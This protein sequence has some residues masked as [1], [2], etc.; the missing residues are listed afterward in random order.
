[1]T[2]FIT[3]VRYNLTLKLSVT[4]VMHKNTVDINIT[5]TY[6]LLHGHKKS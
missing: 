2:K 3:A 1:M 5:N 4:P 6:Y